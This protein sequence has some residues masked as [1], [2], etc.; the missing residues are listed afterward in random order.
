MSSKRL[1][2][3]KPSTQQLEKL[4]DFQ[5][6]YAVEASKATSVYKNNLQAL[7]EE[8]NQQRKRMKN[9]SKYIGV[10]YIL[11]VYVVLFDYITTGI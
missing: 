2:R 10:A 11:L 5:K 8:G 7:N 4:K 6:P 3:S 1:R 9:I